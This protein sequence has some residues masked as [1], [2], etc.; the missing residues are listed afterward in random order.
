MKKLTVVL[1]AVLVSVVAMAQSSKLEGKALVKACD[2]IFKAQCIINPN[3]KID[4]HTSISMEIVKK[5]L[6]NELFE[7]YINAIDKLVANDR[8]YVKVKGAK[9]VSRSSKGEN[10]EVE[11]VRHQR[12][13]YRLATLATYVEQEFVKEIRITKNH[14][15]QRQFVAFPYALR[16]SKG[17][18]KSF[19]VVEAPKNIFN[20]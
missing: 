4:E 9:K 2:V 5:E 11:S 1:V 13:G 18:N 6:G 19:Y 3:H 8:F 10:E 7:Q 12:Y 14:K 16:V 20:K 15:I 17:L